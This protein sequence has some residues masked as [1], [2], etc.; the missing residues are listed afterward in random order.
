VAHTIRMS[1]A[2]D[3]IAPELRRWSSSAPPN[4][5]RTVIV[6]IAFSS[7]PAETASRLTGLGA[8]VESSGP[9]VIVCRL[10]PAVLERIVEL[11]SVRAVEEPRELQARLGS[12]LP[13][14]PGSSQT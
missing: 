3:V 1:G 12:S 13:D 4:E 2:A 11:D 14:D 6:R 10:A 8:R 9:G 7:D 5:E